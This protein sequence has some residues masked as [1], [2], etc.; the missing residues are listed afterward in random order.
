MA[1]I[2]IIEDDEQI[3][4]LLELE[5]K[6]KGY[7]PEIAVDGNIGLQKLQSDHYDIVLLDIM[8]PGIDGI[9]VCRRIRVFSEVTIIM[10]TAKDDLVSKVMALDIGADDYVTKPF[11]IEEILA[12][13]RAALRR[14]EGSTE[15]SSQLR[16]DELIMYID[17]R[18]VIR[19]GQVIHLSKKEFDILECLMRNKD[20]V[21]SR[22]TLLENIWGYDFMGESNTVDVYIRYLRSKVDDPFEKKLIHT[23]RGVGYAIKENSDAI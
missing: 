16:I 15:K 7:E 21:L 17:K 14:N 8:L 10:L 13:I 2:L 6:H 5:L 9:E 23:Y 20:V 12:R 11:A 22:E 3:Y 18:E 19:E 1:R 4:R